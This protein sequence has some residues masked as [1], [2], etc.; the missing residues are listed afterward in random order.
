MTVC[1]MTRSKVKIMVV[2]NHRLRSTVVTMISK[3]N[4]K[5]GILTWKWPISNDVLP[6]NMHVIKRLKREY[7]NFNR[8]GC[9]VDWSVVTWCA[10]CVDVF[11]HDRYHDG[12]PF[13]C[14]LGD[15]WHIPRSAGAAQSSL[16]LPAVAW[17]YHHSNDPACHPVLVVCRS[18]SQS[19]LGSV[20]ISPLSFSSV[21]IS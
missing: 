13:G 3:V 15:L 11:R 7:L 18:A 5:T 20:V 19:V 1:H 16:L 4:G 6:A 8:T 12:C 14:L 10:W 9:Y 21:C 2:W 17:L